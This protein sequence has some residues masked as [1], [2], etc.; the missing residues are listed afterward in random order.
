MP[1]DG[2]RHRYSGYLRS[3]A[4]AEGLFA[5]AESQGDLGHVRIP[6]Q[7]HDQALEKAAKKICNL[8]C[9]LCPMLEEDFSGCQVECHEEI[10]PW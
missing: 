9:G 1:E 10:R 8:K 2:N 5:S 6:V 3:S 4:K 7:L